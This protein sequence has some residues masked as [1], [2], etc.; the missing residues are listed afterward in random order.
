MADTL[1][2]TIF[3]Y[4]LIDERGRERLMEMDKQELDL[5]D[6]EL[7]RMIETSLQDPKFSSSEDVRVTKIVQKFTN[8]ITG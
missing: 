2:K 1:V 7:Q 8:D 4:L 3:P 5:D 6:N